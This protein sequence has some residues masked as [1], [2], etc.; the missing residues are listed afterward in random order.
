MNDKDWCGALLTEA[1]TRSRTEGF[2][3]CLVLGGVL[4]DMKQLGIPYDAALLLAE[5][6][7]LAS[8]E[9]KECQTL[10]TLLSYVDGIYELKVITEQSTRLLCVE[11]DESGKSCSLS[12]FNNNFIYVH[13]TTQ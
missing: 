12:F 2:L 7:S 1:V 9:E 6:Q 10:N 5:V 13:N 11:N 4:K 8:L 3:W